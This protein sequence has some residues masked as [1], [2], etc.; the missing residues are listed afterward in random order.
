VSTAVGPASISPAPQ[1][2]N[3]TAK[4]SGVDPKSKKTP[5]SRPGYQRDA[6]PSFVGGVSGG[7]SGPLGVGSR[8][9]AQRR[10]QQAT[11]GAMLAE[12]APKRPSKVVVGPSFISGGRGSVNAKTTIKQG[13]GATQ[14]NAQL[15]SSFSQSSQRHSVVEGLNYR[16]KGLQSSAGPG[17]KA[18]PG[19]CHTVASRA[20]AIPAATNDNSRLMNRDL[21]QG[22]FGATTNFSQ[23]F[24]TAR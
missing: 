11:P 6:R 1:Q 16:S 20:K 18:G 8:L 15:N 5:N 22:E 13:L 2:P 12:M 9:V 14:T 3:S 19:G 7:P 23:N 24:Q 17:G 21:S 4:P 10:K